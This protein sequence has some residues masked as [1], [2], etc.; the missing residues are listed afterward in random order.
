MKTIYVATRNP[1]KLREIAACISDLEIDLRPLPDDA[2]EVIEDGDTFQANAGKKAES[3]LAHTGQWSLADDS[4]IEVDALDGAP[5]VRSARFAGVEGAGADDANN[6]L[7]LARLDGVP[8]ARRG[9][10]YHCVLALARPDAATATFSGTVEGRILSAPRGD[11]GFGYDPLFLYPPFGCTFAEVTLGRKNSVS[12][13]S[14][15]LTEL[16][17]ALARLIVS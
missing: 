15:A 6:Q 4:G 17:W 2:P 14:Q 3:A 1:H 12:H 16:R 7:L 9:A 13:R 10:R 8:T 5:G 11:G